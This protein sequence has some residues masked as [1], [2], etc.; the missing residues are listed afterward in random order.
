VVSD[1]RCRSGKSR[2]SCWGPVARRPTFGFGRRHDRP[3]GRCRRRMRRRRALAKWL[4]RRFAEGEVGE[5]AAG[6]VAD[7]EAAALPGGEG[8]AGAVDEPGET[9]EAR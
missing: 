8:K 5:G 2:W 6:G 1:W 4:R 3:V 9:T 7:G